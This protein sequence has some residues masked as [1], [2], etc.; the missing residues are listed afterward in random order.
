MPRGRAATLNQLFQ[1]TGRSNDPKNPDFGVTPIP[2]NWIIDWRRFFAIDPTLRP[3]PSRLINTRLVPQLFQL[4]NV[5][6]PN[7]ADPADRSPALSVRNLIRA[8]RTGLPCGQTVARQYRIPELTH[9][10]LTDASTVAR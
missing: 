5:G 10:E 8:D 1:F 6:D 3:S 9:D 7:S 4:H 2:S